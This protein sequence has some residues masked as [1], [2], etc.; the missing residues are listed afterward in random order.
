MSFQFAHIESYSR[1]PNSRGVNVRYVIAEAMREAGACDHVKN[2]EAP[3]LVFGMPLDELEA[4]HDEMADR[5][6]MTNNKGQTRKIRQDQRTLMTVVLSHPG[7]D[8]VPTHF[9]DGTP[10][11]VASVDEWRERSI[12]WL[13]AKYGDDLKTVIE[14]TDEGHPHLHAYIL[15]SGPQMLARDYH[16]GEQAKAESMSGDK[17]IEANR[18]GDKAYRLAMREWQNDYY[19]EVGQPCG[20]A[21]IGP[22]RRR[23]SRAE[24]QAEQQAQQTVRASVEKS[25]QITEEAN[26]E[27]VHIVEQSREFSKSEA[28]QIRSDAEQ[29]AKQIAEDARKEGLRDGASDFAK[30]DYLAKL[31]ISA[32][33]SALSVK[34]EGKRE[35]ISQTAK[36]AKATIA[37]WEKKDKQ[38]QY[39]IKNLTNERD[40]LFQSLNDERNRSADIS[41]PLRSEKAKSEYFEIL[42]QRK[43]E[44]DLDEGNDPLPW[45]KEMQKE[46]KV[47]AGKGIAEYIANFLSM[48][49]KMITGEKPE[50]NNVFSYKI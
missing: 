19:R 49:I 32:G 1:K 28:T 46:M 43:I 18:E 5:A 35:G 12:A 11:A 6:T 48:L 4:L 9:D 21:R 23:L 41:E 8:A 45:L 27:A 31:A 42:I 15:P 10:Q 36:K 22:G 33:V 47:E 30:S 34:E 13:R 3:S 2:P 26:R 16:P 39:K 24:W 25:Q 14:H 40:E 7:D 44:R 17:S 50:K 29:Q 20:L 38:S 37:K